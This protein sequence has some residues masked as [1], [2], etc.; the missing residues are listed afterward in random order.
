MSIFSAIGHFF[1]HLF[2]RVRPGL[3]AFAKKYEKLALDEVTKLAEVNS[4]KGL[5][6]WEQDAFTAIKT[7]VLKDTKEVN[8]NWI[9]ILIKFAYEDVKALALE[10]L[11]KE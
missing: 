7:E 11:K 6:E 10:K 9:G 1:V 3:E 5:H 4:G 2:Q 8:D